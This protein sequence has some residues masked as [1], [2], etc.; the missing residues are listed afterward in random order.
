MLIAG[1][2]QQMAPS[3]YFNSKDENSLTLLH[4]ASFYFKNVYLHYHF[5]SE[6]PSLIAYSNEHFYN[7]ELIAFPTVNQ[8]QLPI[9]FHYIE[10]GLY[11]NRTNE[12]EASKVAKFIASLLPN[13]K[14]KIGIV[15]FSESQLACIFE[16][17]SASAQLQLM[18]RI[19]DDTIFFKALEQIQG[20]ECDRLII[21]FGYAKNEEGKFEMRFGPVNEKN[22][23]K[24]LNV[25]FSRARKN[26][27]FFASVS[28]KDFSLS[29]NT[30]VRLLWKW[31]QFIE[32]EQINNSHIQFPFKLALTQ[33]KNKLS[34]DNWENLSDYA[35]DILTITRTLKSRG[36]DLTVN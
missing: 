11:N 16:K 4:K 3:N 29:S 30:S 28:A 21:S 7:N 14:E 10:K 27:D 33:H 20:D 18:S 13:T 31:F 19:D 9:K 8:A 12:N 35:S 6:H 2:T 32:S 22:G 1:D 26:I 25:L 34:C 36:W 17:L 24:R 23:A 15:A 5:R